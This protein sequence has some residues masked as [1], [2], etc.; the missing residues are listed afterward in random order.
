MKIVHF[1]R[2]DITHYS[3]LSVK[4]SNIPE[5]ESLLISASKVQTRKIN[6]KIIFD[7]MCSSL[8]SLR[9]SLTSGLKY[10]VDMYV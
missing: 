10:N 4:T 3:C 2:N 1:L 8:V 5:A 9:L 6:S 7:K